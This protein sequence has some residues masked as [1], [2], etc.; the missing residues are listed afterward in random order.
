MKPSAAAMEQSGASVGTDY[1]LR[2]SMDYLYKE[3]CIG[4]KRDLVP[5]S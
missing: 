1:Q 4:K 3:G 2:K 5:G